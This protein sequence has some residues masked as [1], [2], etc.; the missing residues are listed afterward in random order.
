MAT[1]N[2]KT[3]KLRGSRTHGWGQVGQHRASGHKGGVGVSGQL[4][5]HF[6][7]MLKE[8]PG[9]FGHDSTHPPHSNAAK[10]WA[11][12]RDLDDFHTRFGTEEGGKKVIDLAAS[13]YDKLLGGGTVSGAYSVKI[14]RLTASAEEKI[15]RAGGEVLS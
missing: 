5:H 12:V 4:K 3:R 14:S 15:K 10:K 7:S 11:S 1:R 2:R 6:S 9:H 13:G 8:D